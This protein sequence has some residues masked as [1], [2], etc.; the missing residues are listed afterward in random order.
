[1]RQQ[2]TGIEVRFPKMRKF[3]PQV[4]MARDLGLRQ[5]REY[6]DYD[7]PMPVTYRLIESD[8]GKWSWDRLLHGW[9]IATSDPS[10]N[11]ESFEAAYLDLKRQFVPRI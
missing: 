8:D 3:K 7:A 11:L 9:S 5:V 1:M 6:V 4:A 2:E 10:A